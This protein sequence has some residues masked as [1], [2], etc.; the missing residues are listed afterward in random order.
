MGY[1]VVQQNEVEQIFEGF[2]ANAIRTGAASAPGAP[3]PTALLI[4]LAVKQ[5]NIPVTMYI[6]DVSVADKLIESMIRMRNVVW[7]DTSYVHIPEIKRE[8]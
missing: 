5:F 6:E 4:E 8:P 3:E 7:K 1:E 2:R